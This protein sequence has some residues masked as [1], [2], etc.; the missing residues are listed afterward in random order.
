[1]NA[2]FDEWASVATFSNQKRSNLNM[3]YGNRDKPERQSGRAGFVDARLEELRRRWEKA[4]DEREK[5]EVSEQIREW[6]SFRP[7]RSAP[8]GGRR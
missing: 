5:S 7:E 1:V 3:G 4:T 2:R 8:S 6:Q